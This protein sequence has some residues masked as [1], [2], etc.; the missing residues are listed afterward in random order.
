MTSVRG[1]RSVLLALAAAVVVL[2]TLFVA[3]RARFEKQHEADGGGTV[4]PGY[5]LQEVAER[6]E[7]AR[8]AANL[9]VARPISGPLKVLFI[10]NALTQGF[11][12][13]KDADSY[14]A[15]MVTELE[16]GGPVDPIVVTASDKTTAQA[17]ALLPT[18]LSADLGLA[19]IELGINDDRW[20]GRTPDADLDRAYGRLLD[21]IREQAPKVALLC[22]GAWATTLQIENGD[23][24]ISTACAARGG[25]FVGL[26]DLFD[27]KSLHGPSGRRT[28]H[29]VADE[30][31]PNDKGHEMIA[32][33]LLWHITV[34][35]TGDQG[36]QQP[37]P[38]G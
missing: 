12:A 16:K 5:S 35:P 7:A 37:G 1:R 8:L 22:V 17:A 24:V 36:S 23:S 15:R 3:G 25:R 13:T 29:G 2:A 6:R 38:A 19:V 11:A 31:H 28:A 26:H 27:R 32:V 30:F 34:G 20:Y 9:Q 4:P 18:D 10:G 14:R 21:Q 33:R